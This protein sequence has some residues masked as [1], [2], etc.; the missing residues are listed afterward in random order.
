VLG[1]LLLV[2]FEVD[3]EAETVPL[4]VLRTALTI[5]ELSDRITN[6]HRS[7]EWRREVCEGVDVL[8]QNL[9]GRLPV[10]EGK[11]NRNLLF[12]SDVADKDGSVESGRPGLGKRQGFDINVGVGVGGVGEWR[13]VIGI[14]GGEQTLGAEGRRTW[15]VGEGERGGLCLGFGLSLLTS[16]PRDIGRL[17]GPVI[18]ADGFETVIRLCKMDVF[19]NVGGSGSRLSANVRNLGKMGRRRGRLEGRLERLAVGKDNWGRGV[20]GN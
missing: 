1:K 14:D 8:A 17:A 16:R 18:D 11:P 3:N 7:R 19:E 4:E 2:Q 9:R 13:G 6:G 20:P 15:R 12:K 10:I 5:G